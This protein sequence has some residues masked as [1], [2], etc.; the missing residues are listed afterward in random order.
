M[1]R[2][3]SSAEKGKTVALEHRPAPRVGRV[4]VDISP[5]GSDLGMGMFQF[6]FER[7]S[8]LLTVLD[9]RPYHY[10]RW[11]VILQRWEPTISPDFPSM[12]PFWI[13][14]QGVPIHLWSEEIA[15]NIGNDIGTFEVAEITAQTFRMRVHINGRLPLIK[16]SV[17]EYPNGD[18]LDAT[19]VYEKLEKHCL[20]CG[21]LD[22]EIRDCLEAKHQK[23]AMLTG[24]EEA[25]KSLASVTNKDPPTHLDHKSSGG[26]RRHS[27]Q[28]ESRYKPY[29]RSLHSNSRE[30]T[31][32]SY[33]WG[34]YDDDRQGNNRYER[35]YY[36]SREE[37]NYRHRKQPVHQV[38]DTFS[39]V[40]HTS[41]YQYGNERTRTPVRDGGRG[42]PRSPRSLAA[43]SRES[44]HERD[45]SPLPLAA[46][47]SARGEV[48]EV[49][50]QYTSCADPSESAARRE[51][52]RQAELQGQL[53]ESAAQ[54]V[55]A[56]LAR[57]DTGGSATI[58]GPSAAPTP[59]A[60]MRIPA[61]KRLGP[62][63]SKSP[64]LT[65]R[66]PI[67]NRLGPLLDEANSTD[68][69][70]TGSLA[71]K[72]KPGRP[73]GRRTTKASPIQ[74]AGSKRRI[75]NAKPPV[76]RRKITGE[77][78]KSGTS[79]G[80]KNTKDSSSDGIPREPE[81]SG[82]NKEAV[83]RGSG[84]TSFSRILP[85]AEAKLSFLN[86]ARPGLI[87]IEDPQTPEN[88]IGKN[89]IQLLSGSVHFS[90]LLIRSA[91]SMALSTLTNTKAILASGPNRSILGTIIR[92]DRILLER[93]GGKN[94][95][96]TFNSLL[97]GAGEPLPMLANGKSNGGLFC[98]WQLE[99]EEEGSFP[100]GDTTADGDITPVVDT[101][102]KK[103]K[104]SSRKKKNKGKR[105]M[106]DEEETETSSKKRRRKNKLKH[107]TSQW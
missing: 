90:S 67:M 48:G 47:E 78:G 58:P 104:E 92:P 5:V 41:A 86:S 89:F 33:R 46:L 100:R 26:P 3:L 18:E 4:R 52:L 55:R 80:R 59:T 24:H 79:K 77:V 76:C 62:R 56:S 12:I 36:R 97:P 87:S 93:K 88:D 60:T 10:A 35:E 45:D 50:L 107:E 16:A 49:M 23:K 69:D 57:K 19:L 30:L 21:K 61:P 91:F 99:E 95:D 11:M 98:N 64:D 1:H 68:K 7:E 84:K 29:S 38:R 9:K 82:F 8:D 39:G 96:V 72:R 2:R 44:P 94:G 34:Q 25:Q 43:H 102:G 28:R 83:L 73:Q 31:S 13:K 85:E 103:S 74:G 42:F 53:E 65:A 22:H 75:A 17:V 20:H 32:H 51:R 15:R 40:S 105:K 101:P 27:P 106:V 63:A 66:V 14:I 70:P 71:Q 6:Q 54:I 81:G 37:R